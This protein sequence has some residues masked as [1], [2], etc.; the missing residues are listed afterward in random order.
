MFLMWESWRMRSDW[1]AVK[2][3]M[4]RPGKTCCIRSCVVVSLV[5]DCVIAEQS[6]A[7]AEGD[8]GDAMWSVFSLING[9]TPCVVWASFFFFFLEAGTMEDGL[10]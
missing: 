6:A 4:N 9:Y 7:M 8:M 2:S 3:P 5:D 1:A 10:F